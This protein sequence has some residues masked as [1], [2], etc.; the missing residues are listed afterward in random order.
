[1]TAVSVVDECQNQSEL[2]SPGR[3][4]SDGGIDHIVTV[5]P[6]HVHTTVLHTQ[7]NQCH[8]FQVIT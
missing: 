3:S 8:V 4:S 1:M 2:V 7:I 5:D 6:K